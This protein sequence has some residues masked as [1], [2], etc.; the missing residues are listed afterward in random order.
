MLPIAQGRDGKSFESVSSIYRAYRVP[1]N[2]QLHLLR[3]SALGLLICRNWRGQAIS[4]R[5]I[6]SALLLHDIGNIVKADYDK[7]P[8]LF[9]EEM[10]N[11]GYWK[12]VQQQVRYKY[13][14]D[15]LAASVSI[16][17][18]LGM[19]ET[20]IELITLKQFIK[21]A[22][23]ATSSSWETKIAAYA[24]QRIGPHGTMALEERLNEAKRRY[25]DVKY[26]SVNRPDFDALVTYAY[27]IEA[28]IDKFSKISL[29]DITDDMLV[30]LISELRNHDLLQLDMS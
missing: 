24:D 22:E 19:S 29:M 26:A 12:M 27:T 30:P 15:D 17:R 10:K 23:T 13:G 14:K 20:V 6:I 4:E 9:P 16:A 21:N 28:D 8:E 18:E 1:P 7:Y 3:V 2:L 11:L 5:T 25:R